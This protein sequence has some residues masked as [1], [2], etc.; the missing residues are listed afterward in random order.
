MT[1]LFAFREPIFHFYSTVWLG[2]LLGAGAILG[3]LALLRRG[4]PAV[5]SMLLTYRSW[6]LILPFIAL[7]LGLGRHASII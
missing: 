6:W 3:L 7:P 1:N 4:D 2:I 5:R